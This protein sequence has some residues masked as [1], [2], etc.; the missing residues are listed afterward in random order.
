MSRFHRRFSPSRIAIYAAIW[1]WAA[2]CLFPLYWLGLASI[3]SVADLARAPSYVPFL[4]FMPS[5]AAWHFILADPADSLVWSF[6]NS[7][8]FAGTAA[9]AAVI[10]SGLAIYG[11]TRFPVRLRRPD[12]LQRPLIAIILATRLV[13]PVLV[14]LPLYM[15]AQSSGLLDT[16]GLLIGV[17]T[18]FNLPVALLLLV[19]VFGTRATPEEEA[20]Q[21]DGASHFE[22]C[23][24]ILFPM[25]R[26]SLVFT[27]LVIFLLCWNEYL[28][29]AYLT[30]G[31]SQTLTL[32]MAGQISIKEA[33]AGGDAEELS[34]MAAASVLMAL[35]AL[36]LAAAIQRHIARS[37]T[38]TAW[39][40][41]TGAERD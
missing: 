9:I 10:I 28:F 27:S 5:L 16:R 24:G 3:K 41:K 13:P 31:H 38:G 2:I 32:W 20:A 1:I 25:L 12:F 29:A 22:I 6:L 11:I 18:A 23:F 37:L 21:I 34:H 8:L 26:G 36:A 39:G 14:A 15:M 7:L 30:S 19:P 4:D 40:G 33:Q 35:P 17:Y